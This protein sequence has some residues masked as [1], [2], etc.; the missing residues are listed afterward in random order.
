MGKMFC[1][2]SKA[3]PATRERRHFHEGNG[4]RM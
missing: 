1:W 2:L 3:L 4:H